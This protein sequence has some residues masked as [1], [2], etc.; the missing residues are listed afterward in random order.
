MQRARVRTQKHNIR[1]GEAAATAAADIDKRERERWREEGREGHAFF[2]RSVLRLRGRD[3][4]NGHTEISHLL[5]ARYA[6]GRR[7]ERWQRPVVE[8]GDEIRLRTTHSSVAV[9]YL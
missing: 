1:A 6:S 2:R 5:G 4:R 7:R 3:R 9:E 8:V